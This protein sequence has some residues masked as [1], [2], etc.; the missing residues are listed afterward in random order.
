MGAEVEVV[1]GRLDLVEASSVQKLV[2]VAKKCFGGFAQSLVKLSC[3]QRH[4]PVRAGY[5]VRL[6]NIYKI[7]RPPAPDFAKTLSR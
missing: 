6:V 7:S 3:V 1:A 2:K 4:R 5:G